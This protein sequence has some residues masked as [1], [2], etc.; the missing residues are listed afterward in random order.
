MIFE[1]NEFCHCILRH[2]SVNHM[3]L[4][5]PSVIGARNLKQLDVCVKVKALGD[6]QY[7]K[8]IWSVF[9]CQLPLQSTEILKL[10]RSGAGVTNTIADIF[11][12]L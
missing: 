11:G 4:N 5:N 8:N 7:L 2:I 10:D 9:M 12:K 3:E 1:E 6:N